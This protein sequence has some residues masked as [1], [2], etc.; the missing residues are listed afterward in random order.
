MVYSD[1]QVNEFFETSV[2]MSWWRK[3]YKDAAY[4]ASWDNNSI[5][6][7]KYIVVVNPYRVLVVCYE[8]KISGEK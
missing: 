8:P 5:S 1:F 2:I 6:M 3:I 7:A 4:N